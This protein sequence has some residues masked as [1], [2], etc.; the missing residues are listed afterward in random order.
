MGISSFVFVHDLSRTR[1]NPLISLALAQGGSQT[2]YISW[3]RL[4]PDFLDR[5]PY[6][7][8]N[9][10]PA[11]KGIIHFLMVS[12]LSPSYSAFCTETEDGSVALVLIVEGFRTKGDANSWLHEVMAPYE[13]MEPGET[14][15]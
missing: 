3:L 12:S 1:A 2:L 14:I 15:H 5:P 9:Q 8:K 6:T 13:L 10:W 11:Y 7:P 4:K